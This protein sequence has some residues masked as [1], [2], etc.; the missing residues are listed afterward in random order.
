V[1]T[2]VLAVE[3]FNSFLTA[4][5]ILASNVKGFGIGI[6]VHFGL[7]GLNTPSKM[8]M[9]EITTLS[10]SFLTEEVVGSNSRV[11]GLCIGVG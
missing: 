3:L 7:E 10:S 5:S 9:G 11:Y 4:P 2:I 1:G 8:I 6:V